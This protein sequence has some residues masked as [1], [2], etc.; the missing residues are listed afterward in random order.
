MNSALNELG[1]NEISELLNIHFFK[2]GFSS[3]IYYYEQRFGSGSGTFWVEAEAETEALVKKK[4]EAEV[5][6]NFFSSWKRKL[7]NSF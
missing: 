7:L 4:L 2:T 5:E 6:A 1:Y 3:Q